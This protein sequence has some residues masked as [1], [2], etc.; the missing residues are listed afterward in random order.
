M[1]DD[2]ITLSHVNKELGRSQILKDVTMSVKQGDIFGYLGPNGAGKTTT[3]RIILGLMRA[4]SGSVSVLGQD[5][6]VDITRRKIGFVLEADGLYDNMTATDNLRY[7]AQLYTVAQP[8]QKVTEVLKLVGLSDR[9]GDKVAAYSKGMR[10]RLAL[11]RAMTPD[12]ELL[13]LDEPTAG[14]DPTGQIEIRQLMLDLIHKHGKTILLSSHNLDEVQRICD[15]IALINKGEI[16]LY[17]ELEQL[18]RARGQ[19]GVEIETAAEIPP[20]IIAE[21]KALPGVSIREQREKLLTLTL[22]AN[23]EAF[24]IVSRLAARG[25][26][27]EGFKKQAASLEEMYTTIVKEAE[28]K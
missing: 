9:A 19:G 27:I 24:D 8:S 11:A 18:Q 5:V 16:K 12:P 26:K 23:V 3:I 28:R 7:Y 2:I 21:L 10:Q 13:V 15:R 22:A 1:P 25:V 14:V 6:Q 4:N 17:G 20:A